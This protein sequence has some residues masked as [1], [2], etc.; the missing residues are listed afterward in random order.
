MPARS[1]VLRRIVANLDESLFYRYLICR[2][3][4]WH[5]ERMIHALTDQITSNIAG[6]LFPPARITTRSMPFRLHRGI[7]MLDAPRLMPL[8][9]WDAFV[10]R[11][12]YIS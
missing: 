8:R 7:K 5:S 9:K 2:T 1:H 11:Y 6:I 10:V 3:S 12:S 4:Q